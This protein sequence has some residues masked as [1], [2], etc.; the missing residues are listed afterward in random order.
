[1]TSTDNEDLENKSKDDHMDQ[2]EVEGPSS[3]L[4][5]SWKLWNDQNGP[6][7]W[8]DLFSS[9]AEEIYNIENNGDNDASLMEAVELVEKIAN[10]NNPEERNND[11][12][13]EGKYF[14]VPCNRSLSGRDA[15]YRHTLSELHFKRTLARETIGNVQSWK[16]LAKL[17]ELDNSVE[18]LSF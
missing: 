2:M 6:D 7:I 15:Y 13:N 1:M 5:S 9:T 17:S 18:L 10:N 12:D 16:K 14:C 3:S 11:C 8:D 4:R